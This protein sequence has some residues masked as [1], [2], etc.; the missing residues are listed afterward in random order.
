M[1]KMSWL[2]SDQSWY[3]PSTCYKPWIMFWWWVT[4]STFL[5][6]HW[7]SDLNQILVFCF[8]LLTYFSS[9]HLVHP[10]IFGKLQLFSYALM[11]EQLLLPS[12]C[13][14]NSFQTQLHIVVCVPHTTLKSIR[15]QIKVRL[16]LN[17]HKSS[18]IIKC[19]YLVIIKRRSCRVLHDHLNIA[20]SR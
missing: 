9:T 18:I 10:T 2:K 20:R 19:N 5:L 15:F 1:D 16:I 4:G 13:T 17:G 3:Y 12:S 6:T 8:K 7:T 11:K 14:H